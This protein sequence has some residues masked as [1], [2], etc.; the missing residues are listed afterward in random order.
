MT[1]QVPNELF[2]LLGG[3]SSDFRGL[4]VC[5]WG[6]G[7]DQCW[8]HPVGSVSLGRRSWFP[9]GSTEVRSG[10]SFQGAL[11]LQL[12]SILKLE[13]IKDQSLVPVLF[14]F[15]PTKLFL[16]TVGPVAVEYE[17]SGILSWWLLFPVVLL[18][19]PASWLGLPL[20]RAEGGKAGLPP[21]SWSFLHS[22]LCY[23][24]KWSW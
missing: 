6:S 10:R 1:C 20:S 2:S 5:C 14:F 9:S 12:V 4:Y 17:G 18:L 15:F 13:T 21:T 16:E 19:G 11:P 7:H 24:F 22:E 8:C 23:K 3:N